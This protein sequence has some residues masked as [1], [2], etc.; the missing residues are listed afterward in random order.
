MRHQQNR[1]IILML[2][3]RLS[4][5]ARENNAEVF[6]IYKVRFLFKYALYSYCITIFKGFEIV[7]PK[8]N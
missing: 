2:E 3:Q 6:K 4:S 8:K 5:L 1:L 7:C